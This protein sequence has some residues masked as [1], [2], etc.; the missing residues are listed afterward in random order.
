MPFYEKIYLLGLVLVTL[1]FAAFSFIQ[2]KNVTTKGVSFFFKH[3][4]S[5][6]ETKL[7]VAGLLLLVLGCSCFFFGLWLRKQERNQEKATDSLMI[8][9]N[10][11]TI[12]DTTREGM[13]KRGE[14]RRN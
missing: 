4:F 6:F 5:K 10:L 14:I 3:D 7:I 12:S 8:F 2:M 13:T 11:P 1:G 9:P